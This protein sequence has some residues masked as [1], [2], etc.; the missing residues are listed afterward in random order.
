MKNVNNVLNQIIISATKRKKN[1]TVE[2][3]KKTLSYLDAL[4][5]L[6]VI[7]Y[8]K[9]PYSKNLYI[10]NIKYYNNKP[11]IKSIKYIEKVH[12]G[13]IL[14][15]HW[16]QEVNSR[17]NIYIAKTPKGLKLINGFSRPIKPIN[18][19]YQLSIN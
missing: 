1:T 2:C 8:I 11:V 12:K 3:T 4:T 18:L 19:V 13:S 5:T 7:E 6:N 14:K 10:V 9:V 17:K 15:N 16:V